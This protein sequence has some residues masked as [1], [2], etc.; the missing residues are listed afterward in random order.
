ME[1]SSRSFQQYINVN[2]GRMTPHIFPVGELPK[3]KASAPFSL[4]IQRLSP[5][6]TQGCSK[7]LIFNEH[8][9]QS[10]KS[11]HCIT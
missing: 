6:H 8:R 11:P 2:Q 5:W 1:E 9:M 10:W 7:S 4:Q 3:D